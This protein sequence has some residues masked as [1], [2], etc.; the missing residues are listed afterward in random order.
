MAAMA[1]RFVP[2]LARSVSFVKQAT[3]YL[4]FF[5][6]VGSGP[7]TTGGVFR[8]ASLVIV[9]S[10]FLKTDLVFFRVFVS[11][12]VASTRQCVER[13]QARVC[14]TVAFHSK[15]QRRKEKLSGSAQNE[16]RETNRL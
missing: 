8:H 7:A 10:V 16:M 11:P 14:W 5:V 15:V 13:T 9:R 6:V 12:P 1:V 4:T 3:P 2:V